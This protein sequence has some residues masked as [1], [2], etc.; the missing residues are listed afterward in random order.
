MA[1]FVP[2]ITSMSSQALVYLKI[3]AR[4]ALPSSWRAVL[5][6]LKKHVANDALKILYI[7]DMLVPLHDERQR[8]IY[9]KDIYI[10]PFFAFSQLS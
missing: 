3:T 10:E 7:E 8:S 1:S 4:V 6:A 5:I 2:L 9:L